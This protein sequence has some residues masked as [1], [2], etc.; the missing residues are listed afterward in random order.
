MQTTAI[1]FVSMLVIASGVSV[2]SEGLAEEPSQTIAPPSQWQY[3]APLIATE[4]REV[5]PSHAQKDPTV[6]FHDGRWHVFMTV[7][8][9]DRSAIE[10]CSFTDWKDANAAKRTLLDISDSDYFCAPQV[11]YF[12]PHKKWYLVYQAGMPGAK[13]MWVAYSTTTDIN[14][15]ASWTRAKPMLDGGLDDPRTIG[16]LDYWII[17]DDAKAHLFFTSLNGKMW[18]MWTEKNQ[19]PNGFDHCEI[20]LEAEVFEA[21]HTYRVK[22]TGKYITLIEQKGRRY[23]KSYIADSLN[24]PWQPLADTEDNPFAGM[25]NVHPGAG[26][27][28]WTDNISHGELLRDGHDE[29]LTVDPSDWRFIFQGMLESDK[30]RKGYGAFQWRIGMLTPAQP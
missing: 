29:T 2:R 3:S 23:F 24:G 9:P 8:L 12:T 17:C 25:K 30:N 22:G 7:K 26:I 13:K 15:P 14:D 19:F 20:A 21:S 6:V 10:H 18:H 27:D 5:E 16:G 28:P 1:R 11:F 4:V